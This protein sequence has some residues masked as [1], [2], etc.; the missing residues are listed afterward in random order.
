MTKGASNDGTYSASETLF[1]GNY[2]NSCRKGISGFWKGYVKGCGDE[3]RSYG[4]VITLGDFVADQI[5]YLV[6]QIIVVEG[7]GF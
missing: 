6:Y 1:P 5:G 7:I 3:F 2:A 4:S